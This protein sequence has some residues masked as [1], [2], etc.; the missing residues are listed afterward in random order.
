MIDGFASSLCPVYTAPDNF[1][2]R[3]KPARFHF[4]FPRDR[5]D[6]KLNDF[7][8]KMTMYSI[9]GKKNVFQPSKPN[10]RY[11]DNSAPGQFAPDNYA[12]PIFKQLDPHSFI[13]NRATQTANIWTQGLT[14]YTLFFV[15]L[16]TTEQI[17]PRSFIHNRIWKSGAS[18][19]GRIVRGASC[20]TF[21]P[22]AK[23]ITRDKP[24]LQTY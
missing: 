4:A 8:K 20:P 11:S 5:Q 1:L 15:L 13:H 17:I 22:K 10:L 12:P 2:H 18:C 19:L 9:L 23:L 6:E 24:K 7:A 16:P 14:S 21:K 3:Q